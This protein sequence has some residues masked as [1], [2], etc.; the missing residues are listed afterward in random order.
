MTESS[1]YCA[2]VHKT[3]KAA[4]TGLTLWE[5]PRGD[6][7][8]A[9]VADD[10][11]FAGKLRAGMKIE[12]INDIPCDGLSAQ[13]VQFCLAELVGP[14]SVAAKSPTFRRRLPRMTEIA[15][16]AEN[17]EDEEAEEEEEEKE[18]A[19]DDKQDFS[20]SLPE[21]AALAEE[22][23]YEV[24]FS[25]QSETA[26]AMKRRPLSSQRSD[27]SLLVWLLSL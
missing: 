27:R 10:G 16:E 13:E 15:E 4:T 8:V 17:E 12:S 11:L 24:S 1:R 3:T 2:T 9:N 14:V 26:E 6:I 20:V 5:N 7:V 25:H 23:C 19:K 21:Q 18:E 22:P